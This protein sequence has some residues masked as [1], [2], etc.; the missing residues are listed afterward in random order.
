MPTQP[1][2]AH[3]MGIASGNQGILQTAYLMRELVDKYKTNPEIRATA[4]EL[5]QH[6][7]QKD[8][9]NEIDALFRFVRDDIRYVK[10][11]YDVETLHT[12]DWMLEIRQGDCDDKSLL[13]ASLLESIGYRTE[14]KIAGYQG[15]DFQHVYVWVEGIGISCHLDPTEPERMGWEAPNATNWLYISSDR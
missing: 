7:P 12:P 3:M 10:D 9:R 6:L 8:E 1:F 15:D 2:S 5:V 13:L 14:F 4:L 11:I